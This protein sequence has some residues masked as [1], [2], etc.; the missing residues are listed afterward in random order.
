MS[1]KFEKLLIWQKAMDLAEEIHEL[2]NKS[3]SRFDCIKYC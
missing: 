3:G 1:F 2:S